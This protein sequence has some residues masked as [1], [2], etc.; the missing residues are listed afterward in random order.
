[1]FAGGCA[2]A[3]A[4]ALL[5]E[6]LPHEPGGWPWATLI[7]NVAG[8]FAL[9]WLVTRLQER[10]PPS[11]YRRP[12]L[13]TGLCGA[14]T[15]FSTFQV[16]LLDL[17]DHDRAGVAAAYAAVSL[18]AGLAAVALATNVARARG[19]AGMSLPVL[20]GLALIGGAGAVARF[21][22]DGAVSARAGR[23]FPW[24][25]LAVNLSGAFA[26]GVLSGRAPAAT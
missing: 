20:A 25:T 22:L 11:L 3:V 24:G 6:G 13:G 16:E 7:V 9:G 8:A 23:V 14:L 2:G 19:A 26:L 1:M 5:G 10:V 12:L 21:L 17:L 18:A 15:T 4:R